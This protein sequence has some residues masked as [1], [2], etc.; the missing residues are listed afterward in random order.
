MIA[1]PDRM[2]KLEVL[3]TAPAT[4]NASLMPAFQ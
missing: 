2:I 1:D 4:E 3:A